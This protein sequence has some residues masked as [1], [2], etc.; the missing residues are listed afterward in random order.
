M[1]WTT[2]LVGV[3]RG[4]NEGRGHEPPAA[5]GEAGTLVR[6]LR[7]QVSNPSFYICRISHV[8]VMREDLRV[9][10]EYVDHGAVLK[11]LAETA[12]CD[13]VAAVAGY[14]FFVSRE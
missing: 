7:N 1:F 12:Y 6:R 2:P 10:Y 8:V 4:S 11:V 3:S 5:T 13:A 9:F 14:L